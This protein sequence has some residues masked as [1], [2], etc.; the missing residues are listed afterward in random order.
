MV[1]RNPLFIKSEFSLPLS[2]RQASILK[3]LG[4]QSFIHQVRILSP[5]HMPEVD[6]PEIP[7]SQSF[8]HQVRI[9]SQIR[10]VCH[11]RQQFGWRRNP[12]FIKSEFSQQASKPSLTAF[13]LSQSFIHQVRILS[14]AQKEIREFRLC[15]VAILYSSS[16][17]SLLP[18]C[19]FFSLPFRFRVAILYSSSQNSLLLLALCAAATV[20]KSQSFIHQVRILSR[21]EQYL[22]L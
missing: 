11:S 1:S 17:N 6:P 8:I 10:K 13:I 12:L 2:K 14:W 5:H 16:Q 9:L 7:A 21:M 4:S 22:Q 20:L 19:P 18:A 3:S 15:D